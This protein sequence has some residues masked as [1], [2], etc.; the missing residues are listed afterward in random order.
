MESTAINRIMAL[1]RYLERNNIYRRNS[2]FAHFGIRFID[3]VI[4]YFEAEPAAVSINYP[5][6]LYIDG[7]CYNGELEVRR[8]GT[9][10]VRMEH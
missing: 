7:K 2:M 5:V 4:R 1:P 6:E 8:D 10:A 9:H 3:T